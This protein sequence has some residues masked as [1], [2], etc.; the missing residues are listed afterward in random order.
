MGAVGSSC[1][2]ALGLGSQCG[3]FIK[4]GGFSFHKAQCAFGAVEAGPKAITVHIADKLGLAVNDVQRALRAAG[5]TL[6]AAVA[7]VFINLINLA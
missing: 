6:S 2:F 3:F 7:Q 4:F 5:H 1:T